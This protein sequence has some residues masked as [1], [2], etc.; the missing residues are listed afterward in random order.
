MPYVIILAVGYD[1]LVLETRSRVLQSAGYLVTSVLSSKQAIAQFLEGDFDLV[2]LCHSIPEK[3]RQRL[4][5]VI[6]EHSS[7][8]PIIF[9]SSGLGQRDPSADVTIESDPKDLLSGLRAV[10][11]EYRERLDERDSY[12]ST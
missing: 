4:V 2:V 1:P 3:E 8:T 12:S 5:S 10:L 6:R 9:I 11:H 7:R